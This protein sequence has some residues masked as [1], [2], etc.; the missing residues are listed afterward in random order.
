MA[1][2]EATEQID[3]STNVLM[4]PQ[5][6]KKVFQFLPA[7]HICNAARVCKLWRD[8]AGIV[9]RQR[10]QYS[11]QLFDEKNCVGAT[12]SDP[13]NIWTK[14]QEFLKNLS[15]RPTAVLLFLTGDLWDECMQK[16][17]KRA[18]KRAKKE[19]DLNLYANLPPECRV[20]WS[21][22]SGIVGTTSDL[23][24]TEEKEEGESAAVICF[25]HHPGIQIIPCKS[26]YRPENYFDHTFRTFNSPTDRP[27]LIDVKALLLM[28]HGY[29]ASLHDLSDI[30]L[31]EKFRR[32]LL[33]GGIPNNCF[34]HGPMLDESAK[35]LHPEQKAE[36]YL[37]RGDCDSG[38]CSSPQYTLCGLAQKK[39][40]SN[41]PGQV[42]VYG[43]QVQVAC[44][45]L[46][47]DV[48]TE[49]L[50][51]ETVLKLKEKCKEFPVQNSV[52]FMFACVA[53]GEE[54]YGKENVESAVFRKHFPTTPLV[55]F[56]GNGEIGCDFPIEVGEPHR[57]NHGYTTFITLICFP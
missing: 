44:V 21:I 48:E 11:W 2:M 33:V 18:G 27:E 35:F 50:A 26:Q 3:G 20:L 12:E 43:K 4:F 34:I 38:S 45:R 7:K 30:D 9:L 5:I 8:E 16:R 32:P 54:H 28:P 55:G 15:F 10:R 40:K 41:Y 13:S 6:V 19:K 52:A 31:C 36:V 37:E 17:G 14:I 53:R 29:H 24:R 22:T 25:G 57:L 47:Q 1:E 49:S 39:T 23:S 46:S 56:F 51:E 42:L